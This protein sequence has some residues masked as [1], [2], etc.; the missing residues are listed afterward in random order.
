MGKPLETAVAVVI[1]TTGTIVRRGVK[2]IV[3]AET[4]VPATVVTALG[5]GGKTRCIHCQGLR[6]L[7]D[8]I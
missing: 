3:P 8:S 2:A 4:E 5:R 7:G 6:P 1:P